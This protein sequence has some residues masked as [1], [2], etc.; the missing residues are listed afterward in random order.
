MGR[1]A[2]IRYNASASR[3]INAIE[4]MCRLEIIGPQGNC[5]SPAANLS[6]G[7]DIAVEH[8]NVLPWKAVMMSCSTQKMTG[9]TDDDATAGIR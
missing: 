5:G 2:F 9:E 1:V 3:M 8:D 6:T 7:L 4:V